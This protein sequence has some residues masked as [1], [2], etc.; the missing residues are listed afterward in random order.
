M[1]VLGAFEQPIEKV[2]QA[3][4]KCDMGC[5]YG[6]Y[7]KVESTAHVDLKDTPLFVTLETTVLVT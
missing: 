2:R 1:F 4:A 5:P 7:T 3:L 6:H